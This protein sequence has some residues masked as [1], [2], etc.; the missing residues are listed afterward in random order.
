MFLKNAAVVD[1]KYCDEA[2]DAD[3]LKLFSRLRAL[4]AGKQEVDQ[5]IRTTLEETTSVFRVI[6]RGKVEQKMLE[7]R[8]EANVRKQQE[9]ALKSAA[10]KQVRRDAGVEVAL[11]DRPEE[12]LC[13]IS[14]EV[15]VDPVVAADGHIYERVQIERW[16]EDKKTSPLTN[17]NLSTNVLYPAH[18]LKTIIDNWEEGEHNHMMKLG[19]GKRQRDDCITMPPPPCESPPPSQEIC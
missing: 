5:K 19:K 8:L 14:Y 9:R 12:H 7:Y 18:A 10:L 16:L 15:M 13:P 11:R 6:G 17:A 3:M 2:L 4:F 1:K